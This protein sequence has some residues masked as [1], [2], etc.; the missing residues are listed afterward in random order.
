MKNDNKP[1]LL[2]LSGVL[3]LVSACGQGPE[4]TQLLYGAGQWACAQLD[5]STECLAKAQEYSADIQQTLDGPGWSEQQLATLAANGFR[6]KF[7]VHQK[8]LA[9]TAHFINVGQSAIDVLN[10]LSDQ[11]TLIAMGAP[12]S[13]LLGP[14]YR[15]VYGTTS[16]SVVGNDNSLVAPCIDTPGLPS[17]CITPPPR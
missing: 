14:T 2:M 1:T 9:D 8:R 6:K 4:K 16:A 11:Q 13:P 17:Y 5:A 7:A 3:L 10:S 15:L 12:D